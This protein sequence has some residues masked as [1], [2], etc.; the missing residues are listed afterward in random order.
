MNTII[1]KLCLYYK[2]FSQESIAGLGEIYHHETVFEDPIGKKIEGLNHLKRHFSQM[3]SNVTY[4]RF[5]ITEVVSD[6]S[7]GFISWTMKFAHP[8]LNNHQEITVLGVSQVKFSDRIT[9]QRDYF[10]LGSMFYE[11]VPILKKVISMLKKRLAA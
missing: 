8:K 5:E 4:C 7:Q 2:E 6:D 3:M 11:H 1:E 10:D 9:Y